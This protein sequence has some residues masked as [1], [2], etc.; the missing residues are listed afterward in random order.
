[1]G[2]AEELEALQRLGQQPAPEA[3]CQPSAPGCQ[4]AG[5]ALHRAHCSTG[6]TAMRNCCVNE[7][8][9][10]DSQESG[11]GAGSPSPAG[12]APSKDSG[13]AL[14]PL[15]HVAFLEPATRDALAG[16][17]GADKPCPTPLALGPPHSLPDQ[18]LQSTEAACPP[19][20]VGLQGDSQGSAHEKAPAPPAQPEAQLGPPADAVVGSPGDPA[21]CAPTPLVKEPAPGSPGKAPGQADAALPEPAGQTGLPSPPCLSEPSPA[22]SPSTALEASLAAALKT[23]GAGEVGEPQ[24]AAAGEPWRGD[25]TGAPRPALSKG[26]SF[27]VTPPPQDA[28]T[29]DTATQVDSRASLVSVAVSPINPPGSA[30]AFPF[31]TRGHLVSVAVSPINPLDGASAFP[32]QSQGTGSA[33]APSSPAPAKKDAEM[34]VSMSVE[35]RSVAT[36]PM[37]PVSKSPQASYPEVRVKGAAEEVPEPIR[38]VSWDE[39]GMTWEVYGAA[40]EVEVLGMAIQ[41]H[42]EKQIEEHGRQMVLTP[43]STRAS[44]IKGAPRGKAK[45]KRPPSVFRALLQNVRRPRCCSRAGPAA[46]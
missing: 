45:A 37:T 8:G 21:P 17:T 42:L 24:E 14:A 19:D 12:K 32:F 9:V 16:G 26:C 44:S 10:P 41:K 30:S 15:K 33:A 5:E 23:G 40:M 25:R 29:Q 1:M 35:T 36:G 20:G 11:A 4:L 22:G 28:G 3:T 39:K 38:E 34:Q 27:E 43:Q 2:S 31:Q 13:S 18:A 7:R 46:E 6:E